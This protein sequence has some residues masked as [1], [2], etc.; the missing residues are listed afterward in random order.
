[1]CGWISRYANAARSSGGA[2]KDAEGIKTG[3]T[4]VAGNCLLFEAKRDG[5]TLIGV[6][7]H[8]AP[9]RDPSAA[10]TAARVVLNWGFRQLSAPAQQP[11]PA[12]PGL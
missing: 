2:D 8:A 10:I 7:L 9:T 3:D 11:D 1:M 5:R 4:K 12:T 6:V